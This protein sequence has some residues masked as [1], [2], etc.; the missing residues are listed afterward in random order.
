MLAGR[1]YVARL[2]HPNRHHHHRPAHRDR[3]EQ[4]VEAIHHRHQLKDTREA[5]TKDKE[6]NIRFA[7]HTEW[8]HLTT[9]TPQSV[10]ALDRPTHP[11]WLQ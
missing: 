5:S 7:R 3:P 10:A 11:D 4:S 6:Q 1:D 8:S 9:T 2:L